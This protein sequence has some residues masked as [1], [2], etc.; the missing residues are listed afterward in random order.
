MNR[1]IAIFAIFA[2]LLAPAC[3]G[4]VHAATQ[5]KTAKQTFKLVGSVRD[6]QGT[7]V[8][9]ATILVKGTNIGATSGV[10]G[11]FSIALPYAEASITVSFIGYAPQEIAVAGRT[12]IDIVLVEDSK[13]LEDVVVVG[14][15][16]QRKATITGAIATL[17]TK[18]LKQSPT[19]NINNAL[20][21]RM[22]GL[23]VNQFSGGEPGN[24]IS[25]INIRGLA[26]YGS[27]D[28]IVIVDGIERDMSYLAA[29]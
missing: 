9:G 13:A 5:S 6:E 26:T 27:K 10:N 7:P 19:A 2:L 29:D 16:V 11:D 21:G 24:D 14:Y 18:D 1:T 25:N 4:G 3:W 15:N 20:A 23:M 17:T 8:T 28:V 22:P 12:R